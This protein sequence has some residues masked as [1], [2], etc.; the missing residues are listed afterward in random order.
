M[1]L[2]HLE[3]FYYV[4]KAGGISR[5]CAIIPYGVQQPAVSAQ[6][7]KLE[8]EVG[9]SLFQRKPFFLTPAG[10]RLFAEIAPFFEKM[11]DLKPTLQGEFSHRL[12]LVATA[13]VLKEHLPSLL[14]ALRHRFPDL[15]AWL[16]ERSQQEAMALLDEGKADLAVT[17]RETSLPDRFSSRDLIRLPMVLLLP[18]SLAK[19]RRADDFWTGKAKAPLVAL[20]SNEMLTRHFGAELLRRGAAWPTVIEASGIE[21]VANYVAHGMGVGLSVRVPQGKLPKGVRMLP[22]PGFPDVVVAAF[23]RGELHEPCRTFLDLLSARAKTLGK[24]TAGP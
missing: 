22:L 14:Q 2:H 23:W 4:A 18:P 17:V 6:I 7:L 8:K 20:P 19:V 24:Q 15:K 13:E 16:Y 9:L 5:A 21:L 3:L 1:N 11:G 12:R 10:K